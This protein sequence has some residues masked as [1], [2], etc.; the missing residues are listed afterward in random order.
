M[1]STRT[2]RPRPHVACQIVEETWGPHAGCAEFMTGPEVHTCRTPATHRAVEAADPADLYYDPATPTG[3]R[4]RVCQFHA[5]QAARL[6]L[7]RVYRFRR[8]TTGGRS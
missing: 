4:M 1:T 8:L 7:T 6:D 2:R 3:T 5:T